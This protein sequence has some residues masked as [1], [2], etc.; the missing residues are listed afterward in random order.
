LNTMT[1]GRLQ[2]VKGYL[3]DEKD[4]MLTYG[5][6]V[7][8]VDIK[9]LLD[10]HYSHQKICTVTAIQ[11]SGKFGVLDM[12]DSGLVQKFVEKPRAG[13]SWINGGFFVL[14]NKVFDYLDGNMTDIMWEQD[15]MKN[16][17]LDDQM[18]AYKHEGFWKSM[19]ILRDKVELES[20][21]Q[22]NPKWKVW[23]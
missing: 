14:S 12:D 18:V 7:A 2:R 10:F 15:P 16:L 9:S 23:S 13:G 6:G 1:A 3:E 22:T 19:D 11:P 5:D 21:W 20:M 17:Q 8:D 4:F